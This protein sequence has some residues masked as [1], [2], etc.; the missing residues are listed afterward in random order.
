MNLGNSGDGNPFFGCIQHDRIALGEAVII[1]PWDLYC[2]VPSLQRHEGRVHP[3]SEANLV[4]DM[5]STDF[6]LVRRKM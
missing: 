2:V 6:A 1:L 5:T 4:V 3:W